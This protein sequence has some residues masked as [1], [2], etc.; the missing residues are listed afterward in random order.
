MIVMK[1]GGSSVND[2]EAIGRVEGII[3]SRQE[4][5]PVVVVSAMALT[6]RNLLEGA[7]AAAAGNE[8]KVHSV[9]DQIE[10]YHRREAYSV[11]P[12]GGRPAL[13]DPPHPSDRL[14]IVDRAA[15]ELHD[16]HGRGPPGLI[17]ANS[18]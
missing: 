6:T 15:A 18:G 2:A 11:V 7:A 9:F 16:D 4:R 13:D 17:D 12:P 1:F 5:Q 8:D 3:R 14:G 10:L